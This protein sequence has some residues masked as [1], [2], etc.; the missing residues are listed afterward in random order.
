MR[1]A[2]PWSVRKPVYLVADRSGWWR[3]VPLWLRRKL[4]GWWPS[5]CRMTDSA[6]ARSATDAVQAATDAGGPDVLD[7]SSNT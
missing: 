5:L 3:R 4:S 1:G 2:R 6:L 7:D